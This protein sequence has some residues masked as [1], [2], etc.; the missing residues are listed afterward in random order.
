M[1]L[2]NR[3][4]HVSFRDLRANLKLRIED[5]TACS[6]GTPYQPRAILVPIPHF[7]DWKPLQ[8]RRAFAQAKRQA[9][10]LLAELARLT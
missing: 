2:R 1:Y 9:A 4:S 5:T 8:K 6:I 3:K 10:Q 7:S